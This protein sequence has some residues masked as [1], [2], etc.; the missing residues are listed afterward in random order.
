VH[1][2]TLAAIT[3]HQTG[4]GIAAVSRLLWRVFDQQATA[5]ARLLTMFDHDTRPATRYEK[6]RFVVNLARLQAFTPTDFVLFSH[7]GLAEV[8]GAIPSVVRRPYGVFLHGIEAWGS[9]SEHAIRTLAGARVRIANS[10]YT[11]N[12][13]A[14]RHPRIGP[15]EVCPL[16]LCPDAVPQSTNRSDLPFAIGSHTV[17]TV[18]RMAVAERYKGHDQLIDAWP[19]VVAAVPDAELVIVGTGDDTNRLQEKASAS[20]ARAQITFAGFVSTDALAQLYSRAAVF[21]LPSRGEGFGL[22]YLEA[23]SHGLP[24]IG[25]T[26]DAAAEVIAD[27]HTGRLVDPDDVTGMADTV[28]ELLSHGTER[29]RLGENGRARVEREFSYDAFARR[30]RALLD[31]LGTTEAAPEPAAQ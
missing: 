26:Q 15:I 8:Q 18:G 17:L 31:P 1:A 29:K 20:A 28:I 12:R 6:V 9:L 27:R 5:G 22:V 10:Q 14:E 30:V 21:A 7:L 23:M 13:I 3:L 4:G 2:P 24:C 16:A 19:R 11:A 25:S